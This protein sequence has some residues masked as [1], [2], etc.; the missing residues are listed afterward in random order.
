VGQERGAVGGGKGWE[1]GRIGRKQGKQR[2]RDNC[3]KY[4]KAGGKLN[5][6]LLMGKF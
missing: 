2:K 4:K 3:K 1:R 6:M 5:P